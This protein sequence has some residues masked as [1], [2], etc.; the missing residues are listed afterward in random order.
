ML[1]HIERLRKELDAAQGYLTRAWELGEP[2]GALGMGILSLGLQ[3][4]LEAAQWL[5]RFAGTENFPSLTVDTLSFEAVKLIA[6]KLM[7]LGEDICPGFSRLPHDPAI[8]TAFEYY[9]SAFAAKPDDLE[10]ARALAEIL[11]TYGATAEAM[12]VAQKA[13]AHNPG[14]ELLGS[15][16]TAAGRASYITVN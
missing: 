11:L 10:I 2:R 4:P 16:F 3:N 1:G 13:L 8:W 14:D 5:G 7:E 6:A 12:E 9:Q 15:I